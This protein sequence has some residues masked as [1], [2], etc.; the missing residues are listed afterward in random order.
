MLH[1][2]EWY[3]IAIKLRDFLKSFRYRD[4]SRFFEYFIDRDDLQIRV[5][6]GNTGEYPAIWIIFGDE[7]D[8]QKQDARIG[9][10]LQLWIDI[11]VKGEATSDIDYDDTL[12]RQLFKAEEELIFALRLFNKEFQKL[13]YG[14]DM[15]VLGIL[16]DGNEN[17]PASAVHRMVLSI[18]WYG[19]KKRP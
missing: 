6:T 9:A 7:S 12:Y 11:C 8:T 1:R 4:G 18:E 14:T 15:K 13:G 17:A 16:S 10:V 19:D 2:I 3:N 5:G